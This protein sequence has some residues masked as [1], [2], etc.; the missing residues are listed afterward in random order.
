MVR[1]GFRERRGGGLRAE[2]PGLLA[3]GARRGAGGRLCAGGRVAGGGRRR[4]PPRVRGRRFPAAVAR[5][6]SAPLRHERA[7]APLRGAAAAALSAATR[8][9]AEALCARSPRSTRRPLRNRSPTSSKVRSGMREGRL[10][11]EVRTHFVAPRSAALRLPRRKS[12]WRGMPRGSSSGA[13]AIRAARDPAPTPTCRGGRDKSALHGSTTTV[14]NPEGTCESRT[15]PRSLV[16][17]ASTSLRFT[18]DRSVAADAGRT[19]VAAAVE[20]DAGVVPISIGSGGRASAEFCG[21]DPAAGPFGTT[22]T[23]NDP[24][25]SP[26]KVVVPW[27]SVGGGES[28]QFA[29]DVFTISRTPSTGVLPSGARIVRRSAPSGSTMSRFAVFARDRHD[30][31]GEERAALVRSVGAAA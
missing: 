27:A 8:A 4:A 23:A 30:V 26:S 19:N 2:R 17:G 15:R 1:G 14:A 5:E 12:A 20:P 11:V 29:T 13:T 16:R 7:F 3:R 25:G 9:A 21:V 28:G 22:R 10:A 6:L 31:G 24:G 18:H